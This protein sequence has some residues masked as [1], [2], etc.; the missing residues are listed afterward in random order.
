MVSRKSEPLAQD[1]RT[2][3]YEGECEHRAWVEVD[4]WA[5][6]NNVKQIRHLLSPETRFMA[7]IKADA[8]GHGAVSVAKIVSE[9]GVDDFAVATIPEGIELRRLGIQQ[10][11]LVLGAVHTSDE[12][13]AIAH[14]GLQPTLCTPTQALLFSETLQSIKR[15][16]P[17][18]L[19]IDTGMSRLGTWWEQA[20][21]FVQLVRGL[22]NLEISGIYSHFATADIRDRTIMDQQHWRFQQVLAQIQ[23]HTTL[24]S[25]PT[26]KPCLHLANSAATLTDPALHYDMVRVG[27]S[28]YGLYPAPHLRSVVNLQPAMSIRA[29]VTQI[30]TIEAG[31]GVSYGYKFIA[32]QKTPI[33]VVGIGYADG[34]PRHLS[35]QMKVLIRGQFVPQIGAITMDQLM[36]DVTAIPDLQVGEV[37]TLL[38]SDRHH[39]ISADDWAEQLG[40]ISWEILCGF[41]HRL[42]RIL[43]N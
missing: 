6:A 40:T 26:V 4:R 23:E 11:I 7:V 22:P 14:W 20:L 24:F 34:V 13:K 28:L 18:Q 16:L 8:Y 27:L 10:P 17:V 36:L 5:I 25:I 9:I 15:S 42:P 38:G 43:I 37:V 35:N 3:T 39:S 41:K 29:R 12:I 19:N 32:K 31:C 33:A 1:D 30:K 21:E 2:Y